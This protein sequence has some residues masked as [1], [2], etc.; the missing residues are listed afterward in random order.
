[1]KGCK[2]NTFTFIWQRGTVESFLILLFS[3]VTKK[4]LF[5]DKKFHKS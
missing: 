2:K 1:M 4:P 3:K 5:S